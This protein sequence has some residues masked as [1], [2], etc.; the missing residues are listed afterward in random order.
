MELFP[1][2]EMLP[3]NLPHQRR[4]HRYY[5]SG[6]SKRPGERK[7]AQRDSG[8]E[9]RTETKDWRKWGKDELREA[10][11]RSDIGRTLGDIKAKPKTS[12]HTGRQRHTQTD[13]DSQRQRDLR[14]VRQRRRFREQ[15]RKQRSSFQAT[16]S[17]RCLRNQ[18][19]RALSSW[20]EPPSTGNQPQQ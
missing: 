17:E 6:R 14:L 7:I 9:T 13:K 1:W 15:R 5:C 16:W 19:Y 11:R 4:I 10:R 3:I 8:T 20:S 12:I 18:R 2:G